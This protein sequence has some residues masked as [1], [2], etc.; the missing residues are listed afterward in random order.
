MS[1]GKV[2]S[3]QDVILSQS[4]GGSE[5]P[6]NKAKCHVPFC[7]VFPSLFLADLTAFKN[8]KIV[9]IHCKLKPK[10]TPSKAKATDTMTSDQVDLGM[11]QEGDRIILSASQRD[12]GQQAR[13]S[14]REAGLNLYQAA[15][16]RGC[17]PC[18][19]SSPLLDG[20]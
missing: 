5:S 10:S 7:E 12:P 8:K 17:L 2:S 18:L 14:R 11:Q 20:E 6:K 9:D 3:C 1:K 16:Q 4:T 19:D 15:H 13:L